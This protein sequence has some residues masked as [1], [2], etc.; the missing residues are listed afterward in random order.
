VIVNPILIDAF[1]KIG[2]S[3]RVQ[4]LAQAINDGTLRLG[5]GELIHPSVT[6]FGERVTPD[7]LREAKILSWKEST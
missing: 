7:E 1:N 4:R 6:L 3:D 5:L 2:P